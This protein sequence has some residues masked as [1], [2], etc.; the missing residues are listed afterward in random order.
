MAVEETGLW[1]QTQINSWNVGHG[2][3]SLIAT[4]LL[5]P[6]GPTHPAL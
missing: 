3:H 4:L 5:N 2:V 1:S 6:S